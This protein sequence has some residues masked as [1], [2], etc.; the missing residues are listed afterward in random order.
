LNENAGM[1][2]YRL[3]QLTASAVL[4]ACSASSDTSPNNKPLDISTVLAQASAGDPASFAGVRTA[5]ALPTSS[6]TPTLPTSCAYSSTDLRFDCAPVSVGGL[7][8]TTSYY[9]LDGS[10]TS[11]TTANATAAA[12]VRVLTDITGTLNVATAGSSRITID[13]HSDLTLS[14]LLSGPRVI[15]GTS[16][17]H[18]AI[19]TAATTVSTTATIDLTSTT[20]N[21]VLPS[22][23]TTAWPQSGT[24]TS[25]MN[26]TT[27]M[28]SLPSV[29]VPMNAVLTFNGTSVVTVV[30]TISGRTETCRIDLSGTVGPSCV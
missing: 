16:T 13:K 11:L 2:Q 12:A 23:T 26:T 4:A 7:T 27:T 3:L 24:I 29:Q 8:F 9:I 19:T 22:S 6:S 14:G 30:A 10:G 28:G 5:W 1:K 21:V 20:S 17:E 25:T 18:D 15:N